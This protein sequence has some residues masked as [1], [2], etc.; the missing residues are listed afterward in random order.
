MVDLRVVAP[1]HRRLVGRTHQQFV[2][3][4]AV[5]E[6]ASITLQ[7]RFAS[8][9]IPCREVALTEE[10]HYL[11]VGVGEHLNHIALVIVV[12]VEHPAKGSEGFASHQTT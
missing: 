9:L 3:M 11:A 7:H 2:L 4:V 5:R 6:P 8:L 10:Q 1:A 12:G